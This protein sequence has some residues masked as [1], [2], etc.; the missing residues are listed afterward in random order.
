MGH[1]AWA[2]PKS[3]GWRILHAQWRILHIEA[4]GEHLD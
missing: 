3:A 1:P 4:G 2:T